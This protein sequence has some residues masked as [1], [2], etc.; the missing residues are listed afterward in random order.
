M[1]P[2]PLVLVA[3]QARDPY[4][5][6]H[7][8]E[9][10]VLHRPGSLA[11]V[12]PGGRELAF[13][14]PCSVDAAGRHN[15]AVAGGG[16]LAPGAFF[17]PATVIG[18][19]SGSASTAFVSQ[20]SGS[21]R[22]QGVFVSDGTTL[23]NIAL[24]CGALGGGGSTGVCGDPTP[25]G[26]T[27]S[28]FFTGTVFT[29][30]VNAAGDVLFFAEVVGGSSTRGLFLYQ[31]ASGAIVKVAVVGDPSP[32]GGTFAIVGPGSLNASGQVAFLASGGTAG[33][34]DVF[35]WSAGVVTKVAASGDVAPL[36]STY[37]FLGSESFGFVDGS[38]I[39]AGPVP[40]I[41][42]AGNIVFRAITF[43]GRRGI[44]RKPAVGAA[45]WLVDNTVTSPI[46]GLFF[47][48]QGA[49]LNEAGE[50][51]FF[52]DVQ[53]S[54]GVFNSGWFVGDGASFRAALVFGDPV[55]A[56]TANG[57]AF[58]RNPM[59]P[60]DDAGNLMLWTDVALGGGGSREHIVV[61]A[62]D[63]SLTIVARQTDPAPTGG[64]YGGFDAWP[65]LDAHGRGAFGCG[66]PGAPGGQVSAHFLFEACPAA[67]R[68][69]RNGTGVN[70]LCLNG[71]APV[72]GAPWNLVVNANGHTG[73]TLTSIAF[74]AA[75]NPGV[76]LPF[77][78][79]LIDLSS[80]RLFTSS[81]PAAGFTVHTL[82]VP[83]D[84]SLAG[85][86]LSL[87]ALIL[88]GSP[89]LCNAIDAVLGF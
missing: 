72:L 39:P 5:R 65:S 54:P 61:S 3:L 7:D 20:V 42:D 50:I 80:T 71:T 4:V 23:T 19:A 81:K 68:T 6:T 78:E 76:L 13:P 69:L 37:Q 47:D 29:P 84:A 14:P 9:V 10:R 36:G 88:G 57:L 16:T 74:R 82:A 66:T 58:S 26:G 21:T 51:A 33:V 41:D 18:P 46:G 2:L 77:G 35:L 8:Q 24:G 15:E 73:A 27:F 67:S 75:P 83:L 86:P 63:G 55:G 12:D 48:I 31:G 22:N 1:L 25:I 44:V 85:V 17:N 34:S 52:A 60:L 28:G 62:P 53:L 89:E 70:R 56:G 32:L 43:S 11:P 59:T 87:Q 30:A 38:T 79:L 40:D 49:C 45:S 64:N